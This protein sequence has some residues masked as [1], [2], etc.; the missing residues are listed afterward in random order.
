MFCFDV[1]VQNGRTKQPFGLPFRYGP[2]HVDVGIGLFRVQVFLMIQ[3]SCVSSIDRSNTKTSKQGVSCFCILR[4]ASGGDRTTGRQ[5]IEERDAQVSWT[6]S[7]CQNFRQTSER[8]PIQFLGAGSFLELTVLTS[9]GRPSGRRG[10]G[11]EPVA[12]LRELRGR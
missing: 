12:G 1:A 2:I 11:G 7:R 9:P 5:S 4:L 6:L 3:L 10:L 8:R